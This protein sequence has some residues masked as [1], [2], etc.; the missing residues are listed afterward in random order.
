MIVWEASVKYFPPQNKWGPLRTIKNKQTS[1]N[2]VGVVLQ[3][4]A[5]K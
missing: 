5:K 3:T 4:K 2:K 1:K